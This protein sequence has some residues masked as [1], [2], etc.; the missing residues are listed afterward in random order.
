MDYGENL[1]GR[2]I[3]DIFPDILEDSVEKLATVSLTGQ[4]I[5]TET[6]F[7]IWNKWF[8]I[9]CFNLGK[10]YLIVTSDNITEQKKYA[11]ELSRLD[12]LNL[13]GQMAAGI[14]S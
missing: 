14:G 10:G 9:R 3:K 7:Q 6:Y 11:D 5:N 12:R 8:I 13:I 2:R 4:P 1:V